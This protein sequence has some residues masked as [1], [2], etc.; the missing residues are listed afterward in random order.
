MIALRGV[1]DW[2][3]PHCTT[4][5]LWCP[6]LGRR[7]VALR[8]GCGKGGVSDIMNHKWFRRTCPTSGRR[9]P[10]PRPFSGAHTR[11]CASLCVTCRVHS[12]W[13][14][15]A[16]FD[17]V[18]QSQK[19]LGAPWVPHLKDPFDLSNF[20]PEDYAPRVQAYRGDQTWCQ[21]F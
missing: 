11:S 21:G 3:R 15:L 13:R 8:L 4:L 2:L 12:T 19:R 16:G 20:V 9:T 1:V 7:T 18:K 14:P 17:W 5:V 10:P 6:V